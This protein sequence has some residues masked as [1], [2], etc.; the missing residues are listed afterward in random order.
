MMS[1]QE[2]ATMLLSLS[3]RR[4][5]LRM[6]FLL[7]FSFLQRNSAESCWYLPLLWEVSLA[8]SLVLHWLAFRTPSAGTVAAGHIKRDCSI[9]GLIEKKAKSSG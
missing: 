7:N 9:T 6:T 3:C 1:E 2:V 4:K 8:L 5:L